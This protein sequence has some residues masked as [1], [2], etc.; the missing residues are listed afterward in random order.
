LYYPHVL[1]EPAVTSLELENGLQYNVPDKLRPRSGF[2]KTVCV[3][4]KDDKNKV[5]IYI[6]E[7]EGAHPVATYRAESSTL[8]KDITKRSAAF[9]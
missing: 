8:N 7:M 6:K 2:S 1:Q 3:P 9:E 5:F 4:Y